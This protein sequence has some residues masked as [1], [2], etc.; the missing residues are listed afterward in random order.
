MSNK[1]QFNND[2]TSVNIASGSDDSPLSESPAHQPG[3]DAK[4][5]KLKQHVNEV[6]NIMQENIEKIL[7]SGSRLDHLEDRSEMLSTRAD[8][9]RTSARRV[10]RKMWWQ[11]MKINI[12]I[13]SIVIVIIIIIILS[14]TT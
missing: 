9:F 14:L 6:S 5:Q 8:E 11:N 10:S 13:A 7:D 2:Y 12:I 4:I 1:G 3:G